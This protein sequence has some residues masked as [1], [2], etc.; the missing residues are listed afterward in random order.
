MLRRFSHGCLQRRQPEVQLTEINLSGA[1]FYVTGNH[2]K[3]TP[4]TFSFHY[5]KVYL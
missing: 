4:V 2:G 5:F 3:T 1:I